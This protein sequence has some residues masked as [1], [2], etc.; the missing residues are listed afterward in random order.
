MCGQAAELREMMHCSE[1]TQ[2]REELRR[3]QESYSE[4]KETYKG[5][6]RA[7]KEAA[8]TSTGGTLSCHSLCPLAPVTD[9]QQELG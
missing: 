2:Q 6:I 7:K 1:A 4:A 5:K 9:G 8:G 3:L